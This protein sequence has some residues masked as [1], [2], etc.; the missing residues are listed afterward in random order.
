MRVL[1]PSFLAAF[2]AL[3][4]G[5]FA[6]HTITTERF[7]FGVACL[8]AVC[9]GCSAACAIAFRAAKN[10]SR[11]WPRVISGVLLLS[12]AWAYVEIVASPDFPAF[13]KIAHAVA[14]GVLLL[15]ASLLLLSRPKKNA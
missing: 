5:V 15:W 1:L 3:A 6:H 14:C 9:V 4:L 11:V 12:V 7:G 13:L 2:L 8:V 10:E